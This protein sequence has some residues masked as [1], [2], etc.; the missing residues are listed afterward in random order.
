MQTINLFDT[1][2][3]LD[4]TEFDADRDA[5]LARAQANGVKYMLVPAVQRNSWQFLLE[6][7]RANSGLYPALGL[8][9]VYLDEHIDVH[10]DDLAHWVETLTVK[11]KFTTPF[12]FATG[13]TV[14]VQ[15]GTVPPN[16]TFATGTRPAFEVP[17][18]IDA[19]QLSTESISVILKLITLTVSSL[20][21]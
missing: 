21:L 16:T 20:V 19:V 3:H 5:V 6:Y 18:L 7:C 1:H 8:H 4:V 9:P 14:A 17:A 10:L 12:A 13:V 11:V 15:F 2:C